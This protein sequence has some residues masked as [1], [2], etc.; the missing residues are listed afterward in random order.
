MTVE[1]ISFRGGLLLRQGEDPGVTMIRA[2]DKGFGS[3]GSMPVGEHDITPP[4]MT[5]NKYSYQVK[6][7]P[8]GTGECIMTPIVPGASTLDRD[9][10]LI[11]IGR[12][13]EPIVEGSQQ[14][15]IAG[16]DERQRGA[17]IYEALLYMPGRSP[18]R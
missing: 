18:V 4:E 14:V 13:V 10:G 5:Q 1:R 9:T 17:L 8:D 11:R 3:V 6:V 15:I 16:P 7:Y 2:L 12:R